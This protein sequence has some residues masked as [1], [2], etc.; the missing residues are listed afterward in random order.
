MGMQKMSNATNDI[1]RPVMLYHGSKFRLAPWII[2][3]LPDHKNYVEPFGGGGAVLL[4]KHPSYHEVYNDLNEEVVNV[5]RVLRNS[6]KS[7]QL[8]RKIELTPFSRTEFDQSY[9]PDGNDVERARRTI[10]RSFMGWG[11]K[12]IGHRTGFRASC[13]ESRS[14]E[15][16]AWNNYPEKIMKF[17][18]RFKQVLIESKDALEV[19]KEQ[20]GPDTL[21]YLD[22]PYV[23]ETR[24]SRHQYQE[25]YT[26][27][28]HRE[29]HELLESIEG[30]AVISGYR[31]D[32]YDDLYDDWE[33]KDKK[34]RTQAN[35]CSIESIWLNPA[36][37][38]NQAQKSLF[39]ERSDF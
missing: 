30:M 27:D 6:E 38:E 7:E 36:A 20:Y 11:S 3:N 25:E 37:Q 29:L 23:M 18:E 19:I 8:K 35:G 33:R 13:R 12:A 26:H 4:R 34:S 16:D 5:F 14:T 10:V 2:S 32:L 39:D 15:V 22:P 24:N 21:L 28:D 1:R 9:E 31:C 17:A